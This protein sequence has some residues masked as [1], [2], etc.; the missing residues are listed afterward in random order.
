[1]KLKFAQ[2][3]KMLLKMALTPK[4]MQSVKLLGMAT[5]DLHEYVES[6]VAANPFLKKEFDKKEAERYKKALSSAEYDHAANIRQEENPRLSFISQV[7]LLGLKDKALEIAEYLIYEMDDNG[8]ITVD[9]EQM[10]DELS[11]DM[12]EIE[13]ILGI[14]QGMEPP[15]IGARD[16]REC[17]QL[18]L[19][20]AGREDSLEHSIVT[21]FINELAK[22]DIDKISKA[23]NADKGNVRKAINNI[24]KLNPRPA[25]SVLGR[26]IAK[27][28][29]DLIVEIKNKNINLILNRDWLPH[30]RFYNPYESEVKITEDAEAKKFIKENMDSAKYLID[31]LKRREDTI[32]K[33]ADY[34]LNFQLE[35]LIE[36]K[37]E[38]KSLT[39]KDVALA[40]SLHTSTISR[41]ISNKYVQIDNEVMPLKALLSK[42]MRKQDGEITSKAA[43]KKKIEILVKNENRARPLSDEA[44]KRELEKEG[45]V[46]KRRTIAK[47]RNSLRIL[48]AYLRKK[49]DL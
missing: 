34:I 11:A 24:K 38:V 19:K 43:V 27:V 4:M 18:Q 49:I 29:P 32:Y 10:A 48:P 25:S 35:G 17:L 7:R 45:I 15:G 39:I 20:R 36:G 6:A 8:Y 47:Y 33:V 41:T 37:K 3:P 31:N 1:M 12:N 9:L 46:I 40:L 23:L 21:G 13:K 42:G 26:E 14:I 30:L 22:N 28:I 44:I 5:K 16:V 2:Y